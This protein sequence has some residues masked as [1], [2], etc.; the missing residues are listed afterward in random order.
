MERIE[1][2]SVQSEKFYANH[3]NRLINLSQRADKPLNFLKGKITLDL[4]GGNF[5]PT[6][7]AAA[8]DQAF[9]PW[10]PRILGELGAI[11]YSVDREPIPGW[12]RI[13]HKDDFLCWYTHIPLD[14]ASGL[15]K[16][17]QLAAQ[18]QEYRPDDFQANTLGLI[19]CNALVSQSEPKIISPSFRYTLAQML[20]DYENDAQLEFQH[21]LTF[22]TNGIYDLSLNLLADR[23]VLFFNNE[24]YVKKGNKLIWKAGRVRSNH[25]PLP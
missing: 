11:S 6:D 7:G 10:A 25:K 4:G 3:L 5:L 18:L 20:N 9:Y 12:A 8:N 2:A 17:D 19:N 13:Q 22:I 21:L 23:G 15:L 16:P 24:V 1:K 14:L